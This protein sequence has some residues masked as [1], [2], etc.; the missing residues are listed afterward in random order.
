M[1]LEK[2]IY[3]RSSRTRTRSD[4]TYIILTCATD[5]ESALSSH[6]YSLNRGWA[7]RAK[8]LIVHFDNGKQLINFGN[9][10]R[11]GWSLKILDLTIININVKEKCHNPVVHY[12]NPFFNKTHNNMFDASTD[13]FPDKLLDVNGYDFIIDHIHA[14]FTKDIY[15]HIYTK[16]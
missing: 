5:K 13:I 8:C 1:E 3:A 2:I 7:Q 4:V 15:V 12:Y 6:M 11:Y 9:I 14:K 16:T 10:M